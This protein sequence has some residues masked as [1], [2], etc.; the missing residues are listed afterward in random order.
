M[1]PGKRSGVNCT[2]ENLAFK[3]FASALANFVLPVPGTS[4]NSTCPSAIKA[5]RRS[6]VTSSF[7]TRTFWI[8]FCILDANSF[9][10]CSAIIVTFLLMKFTRP[11]SIPKYSYEY[12]YSTNIYE[13][14]TWLWI[15][16]IIPYKLKFC[17][18]QKAH[19]YELRRLQIPE[20]NVKEHGKTW[21]QT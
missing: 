12:K 14:L 17:Q 21:S 5:V 16:I 4:S 8:L 10:F 18:Y 15:V 3:D 7:P 20:R 9:P 1:S 19:K 13:M 6:S 2:R 11:I